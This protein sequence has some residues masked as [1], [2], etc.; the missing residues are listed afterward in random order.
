MKMIPKAEQARLAITTVI[1]GLDV[2]SLSPTY[3]KSPSSQ[4]LSK[5]LSFLQ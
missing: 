1:L 5:P 2:S 4:C 3:Q